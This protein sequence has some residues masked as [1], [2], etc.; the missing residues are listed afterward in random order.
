MRTRGSVL[1]RAVAAG[2]IDYV[3]FAFL[4]GLALLVL[5]FASCSSAPV[6]QRESAAF[7]ATERALIFD[8]TELQAGRMTAADFAA[9]LRMKLDNLQAAEQGERSNAGTS[10]LE[11]LGTALGSSTLVGG[12]LHVARNAT[13]KRDLADVTADLQSQID[14]VASGTAPPA[15]GAT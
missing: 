9:D 8:L 13:R 12:L 3:F 6:D 7:Q 14:N 4:F 2:A 10:W 15:G 5:C 11:V 1:D